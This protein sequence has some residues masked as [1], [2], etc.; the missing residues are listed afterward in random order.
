MQKKKKIPGQY[1]KNSKLLIKFISR[2]I[3]IF[4]INM[5][6]KKISVWFCWLVENELC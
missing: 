2:N 3:T 6:K 4:Q 1:I 5:F